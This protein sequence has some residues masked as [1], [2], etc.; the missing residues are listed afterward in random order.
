MHSVSETIARALLP[1]AG[2]AFGL[3]GNGNA[4]FVDALER[5]G[6]PLV[7]V[8][9]EAAAVAS[10]DAYRRV[11][12]RLA[13]ATTTY[14]PG[15]T[16]ALT[17]LADAAQAGIPLI[18]VA[19]DRPES[20]PAPGTSISQRSRRPSA[21]GPSPPRA[22][23]PARWPWPPRPRRATPPA[24]WFSRSPTTSRPFRSRPRVP[25]SRPAARPG[26]ARPAPGE[27]AAAALLLARAERP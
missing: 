13:I 4:H 12:G 23:T 11:S 2:E 7:Q 22:R 19:G 26:A 25:A 20:G 27:V 6:R 16:N 1:L 10:A 17:A 18:L 3:M 15:F 9:H 21:C 8:R 24:P 5:L 14:G